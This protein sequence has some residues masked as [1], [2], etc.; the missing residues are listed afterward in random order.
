MAGDSSE[1]GRLA[2]GGHSGVAATGGSGDSSA[3]GDSGGGAAG[4]V[5]GHGGESGT[6]GTAGVAGNAGGVAGSASPALQELALGKS[7]AASTQQVGNEAS[8]GNDGDLSTRWC[9]TS[10][11]MPQW[12]RV[13]LDVTRTLTQIAVSFEH[14]E[15][16]YSY[17]IE[18]SDNDA[19]YTQQR[20]VSGSGAAQMV[21]FPPG[22]SARYVRVTVSK[23]VTP[24]NT[25]MGWASF[26]EIS[27]MGPGP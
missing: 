11:A 9:A 1:G 25:E 6:L 21:T 16:T 23:A 2:S 4:A 12:W 7:V 19:V 13:D 26:F 14:P 24:A 22:V 3:A 18:T 17:I 5:D 8:R 10:A 27:L 20:T 15:R